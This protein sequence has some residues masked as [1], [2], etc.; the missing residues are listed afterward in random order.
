MLRVKHIPALDGIRGIAILLVLIHHTIPGLIPGGFLG[1][2]IFFV[3]SGFLITRLLVDEWGKTGSISLRRF[4]YRRLLRLGPALAL[5]LLACAL[6][7]IYWYPHQA[8]MHPASLLWALLFATNW[9]VAFNYEGP[10]LT[11]ITWSL[12]IEEQFYM[13]WPVTVLLLM[14]GGAGRKALIGLTALG[15]IAIAWRRYDLL[16]A[17]APVPRRYFGTDT[18]ADTLLVG[19]FVAL[20]PSIAITARIKLYSIAASIGS[21]VALACL[22]ST[23]STEDGV[24]YAG[25]F[26]VIALMVGVTIWALVNV[27]PVWLSAVFSFAPLR[28]FGRISYGLYLYHWLVVTFPLGNMPMWGSVLFK[29][30]VS[31]GMAALSFYLI[32]RPILSLKNRKKS[33]T[34]TVPVDAKPFPLAASSSSA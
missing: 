28:W 2:D 19:C 30:G 1:V 18:R 5:F 4:Y 23:S 10:T 29:L 34:A 17:Y 8:G 21:I 26:T 25:L 7:M 22:V 33:V 3:L 20:L 16:Y 32:E 24:L 13:V 27:R 14:R 11:L 12:S 31:I 6:L 9:H 15:V